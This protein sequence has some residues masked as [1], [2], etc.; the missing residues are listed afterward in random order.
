MHQSGFPSSQVRKEA[1]RL[2]AAKGHDLGPE[3]IQLQ[4]LVLQEADWQPQRPAA[5]L[6][7]AQQSRKERLFARRLRLCRVK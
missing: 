4:R 2:V 1:H 7:V 6:P 3:H 5:A